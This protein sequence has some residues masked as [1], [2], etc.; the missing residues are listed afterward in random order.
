M[1]ELPYIEET[2]TTIERRYNPKYGNDR[3]CQC[4][5]TYYRHF[6][7]WAQMDNVGCKYCHCHNFIEADTSEEN[8]ARL[9]LEIEQCETIHALRL[10]EIRAEFENIPNGHREPRFI[11]QVLELHFRMNW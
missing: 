10:A 7:S 9:C 3:I 6:D 11:D 8:I 2:V 5:H 1:S 4:G